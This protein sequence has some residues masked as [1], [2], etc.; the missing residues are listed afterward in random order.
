MF[1]TV[2]QDSEI[3]TELRNCIMLKVSRVHLK[4]VVNNLDENNQHG[5]R[6]FS[7]HSQCHECKYMQ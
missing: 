2:S 5:S 4:L 3:M 7:S 1:E 6:S